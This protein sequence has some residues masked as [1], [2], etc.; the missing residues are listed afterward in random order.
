MFY[1]VLLWRK[2]AHQSESA[3]GLVS[4][5]K[6][7]FPAEVYPRLMKTPLRFLHPNSLNTDTC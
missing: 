6:D 3:Y 7:S 1:S 4:V 2:K 5:V